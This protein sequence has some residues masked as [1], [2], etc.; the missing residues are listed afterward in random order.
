MPYLN[1]Y[2]VGQV[3]YTTTEQEFYI[4]TLVN[5][6]LTLVESTDFIARTGRQ[7]LYFQY[8]HNSP[9]NRRIDPSP[10]NIIDLYVLTKSYDETYRA[11]ALDSTNTLT[12]P[13]LPT[14]Q[15]LSNNLNTLE[16]YKAVS[17]SLIYS[18]AR[19]KL[20]FGNKASPELRAIFKIVKNSNITISD[21]EIRS[22]T[23]ALINT[24]FSSENWE[25]GETFYFTELATYIQQG[26]APN[27]SSIIIVPSSANQ[28]YGSLQQITAQ[29]DEI[30][31]SCATVENVE[32]ITSI[33]A[34]QLNLQNTAVNTIVI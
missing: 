32:V 27:V 3:F 30:L 11:W 14:S 9:G 34:A 13:D 4:N 21:T 7:S 15:E 10:N 1:D 18:P 6:V 25:F 28:V 17:D 2:I 12:E 29:P 5:G 19:F 26:L 16:D 8:K 20:L 33:T 24:F 31:L 23:V 22:Q